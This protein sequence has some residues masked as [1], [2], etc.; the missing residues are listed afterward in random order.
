M[1]FIRYE[2]N[3]YCFI[4]YT[5]GNIIFH[6]THTIFDEEIFPKY[7][8]SHVKE[9]KLYSK[10]LDK[11]SLEIELLIPNSFGKDGPALVYIPHTSIYSI[12]NNSPTHSSLLLL[13][14]KSISLSPTPG[15]KK[16]IVEIEG[17]DNVNSDIEIQPLSFQQL[18]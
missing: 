11:I 17:N 8:N 13:S 18:L 6:F 2:N 10:L 15:S 1:I 5:Q 4:C 14:Y 9:H 3:G 16:P 7:T 12:Q